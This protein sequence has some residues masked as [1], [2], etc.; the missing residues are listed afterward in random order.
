MPINVSQLLRSSI[1][2]ARNYEVTLTVGI[3]DSESIVQGKIELVHTGQC[4]LVK[5]TLHTT[6]EIACNRCLSLFSCPL[7]LNIAEEYFAATDVVS[8]ALLTLPEEPGYFTIDEYYVLDLTE[9]VYQN[10]MLAIPIKPLCREDCVGLCLKGRHNLSQGAGD[11]LS[12]EIDSNWS[13]LT[14]LTLANNT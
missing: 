5:G 14:R 3:A 7:T 2:T 9:A 6:I 4:I 12:Q 13:E 10:I 1:G 8:G 11:C